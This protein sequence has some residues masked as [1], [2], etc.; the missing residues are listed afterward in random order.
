MSLKAKSI[1]LLGAHMSISQ[2]YAHALQEGEFLGCNTM[3]IFTAS[4][5]QWSLKNCPEEAAALFLNAKKISPLQCVVSHASYLINL[6]SPK[7]SVA[8]HSIAA[9]EAELR[10]CDQ[11]EIPYVIMHPGARLESEESACINQIGKAIASVLKTTQSRCMIVLEN[12]AGQGSTIGHSLEQ[13][14]RIRDAVGSTHSIG[15]CIDTCHA[16][17]AGYDFASPEKYHA[18]WQ[19]FDKLLG[20][21]SLKAM[22]INDSASTHASHVDRHARI[23]QGHMGIQSFAH[24]MRDELLRDIP[25]ILEIPHTAIEDYRED[26]QL[27]RTLI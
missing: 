7:K 3:Q 23:G 2:G 6:G 13:L 4:N 5:R 24:I 27:L 11:L 8:M 12:T 15:F 10:R 16:Y 21:E 18:F 14:A 26:M 17:A 20:R 1:T 22:H 9:L 25:K 19:Q